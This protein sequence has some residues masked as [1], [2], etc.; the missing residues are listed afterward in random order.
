MYY[1]YKVVDGEVVAELFDS[2]KIP[3]GY[4]D[5][6][7]AALKLSKRKNNGNSSDDNKQ[8]RDVS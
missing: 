1:F 4:A 2:P 8:S 6:P 3:K 5:S 7:E